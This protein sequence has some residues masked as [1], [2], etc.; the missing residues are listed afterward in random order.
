MSATVD[1][2]DPSELLPVSVVIPAHNEES[3]IER[4]LGTLTAGAAPG[5]LDVVVVCNGCKDRTAAIAR[6]VAG[7]R[8]VE[9]DV[10]SKAAA[11]NAGDDH[12]THFPRIYLDADIELS[13]SALR[14]TDAKP[15]REVLCAAPTP[16]FEV[17]GRPMLIREYYRVWGELPYLTE[18]MVGTG[19]YALSEA[20]RARF[21]RFP[22][23]TADDQFVLQQ[24]DRT[25]RRAIA[26]HHF[27]VHTPTTI[28][29]PSPCGGGPT[30]A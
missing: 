3:V 22:P 30:V 6:G 12:A 27:V 25:E 10:A 9:L 23:I 28:R 11:L 18:A 8:V 21:G 19:V 24:F 26:D 2:P 20:G 14:A 17:E 29:G 1:R 4:C 7:V 13:L 16:V 5:E 15:H